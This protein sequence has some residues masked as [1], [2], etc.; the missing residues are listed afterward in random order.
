MILSLLMFFYTALRLLKNLGGGSVWYLCI[1]VGMH[2]NIRI[3]VHVSVTVRLVI[4][5]GSD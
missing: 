5:L 2:V 4:I 3:E 1:Y